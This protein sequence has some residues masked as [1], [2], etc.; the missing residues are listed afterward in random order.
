MCG[1]FGFVAGSEA[2]GLKTKH[3]RSLVR[4]SKRRGQDSSGLLQCSQKGPYELLRADFD[5]ENLIKGVDPRHVQAIFGHSRLIT[6]GMQ[7][8]QP[9]R[10]GDTF[11]FH[12]GIVLNSSKIWKETGLTARTN[13]DSEV[14]AAF[15]DKHVKQFGTMHGCWDAFRKIVEG[16]VSCIVLSPRTG[17]GA[18]F[19]NTGSMYSGTVATGTV[20]AS[21]EASLV[22]VGADDIRQIIDE[23]LFQIPVRKINVQPERKIQRVDLVP[24]VRQLEGERRLL[25]YQE[26]DFIRC[27]RC[28]LPETMPFISFNASQ[29]CNYCEN[30]QT[31]KLVGSLDELRELVTPF[32]RGSGNEVIVPFSGGRDSTWALKLIVE[33]L[34]LKAIAYTYDWG[35]VTDLGRRNISL[36]TSKLG[37]EHV[38]VSPNIAVKRQNIK[39]NLIAWLRNPHLGMVSILTAGDKHFYKHLE[40]LK[41]RIGVSLNLWGINPYETT[42]FKAGFLGIKPNFMERNVYRSGLAGQL[43]YQSKRLIQM[44]KSPSY[45][46][47][48]LFDT[49]SGEYFRSIKR[50]RDYFHLFSYYQ[51]DEREIE[52]YLDSVAW[53]RA[54]DTSTTWRIGDGTAGFYNYIYRT[55]A[56]FSEHDTFRS[57]QIREGQISREEALSLV[58]AENHPRYENIKWYLDAVGV[59]FRE[60]ISTINAIPKHYR[61]L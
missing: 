25:E 23:K 1:I 35:M 51:W 44:S 6:N 9:V 38:V 31:R 3:F 53:E 59:P 54:T 39:K 18:A 8:N 56:G 45:F 26:P 36:M 58:T 13:L 37:V 20:W 21:E 14:I 60:A 19:S 34:G 5:L 17:E 16:A 43:E 33:D 30:Y 47:S 2:E 46:N 7:H 41:S 50:K 12:N 40:E 49:L 10:Y 27:R 11:V 61:S 42:H 24:N 28:I 52:G 15:V 55:V 4:D 22:N 32:R 48:S 29:V 57:N